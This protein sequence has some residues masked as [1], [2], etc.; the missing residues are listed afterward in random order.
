[1]FHPKVS[2]TIPNFGSNLVISSTSY[3]GIYHQNI[4]LKIFIVVEQIIVRKIFG[5]SSPLH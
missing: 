2:N 5:F 4:P 1:M 3:Q